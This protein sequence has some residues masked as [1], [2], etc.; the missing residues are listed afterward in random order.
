MRL[1]TFAVVILLVQGCRSLQPAISTDSKAA[2]ELI[3]RQFAFTEGPA[4]DKNGN[5]YFTD[6]PNNSIWKYTTKGELSL[7]MSNSGRSNG[8]FFDGAGNLIACADENNELWSIDENGN[9]TVLLAGYKGERFNG[10]NDVWVST[11]GGIYFTDPHYKRAYWTLTGPQVKGQHVYFLPKGASEAVPV[12]TDLKQPNGIIGS[13]DGKYLYVA[14][15]GAWKTYRYEIMENGLLGKAELF[16]EQGS[17]GMTTDK[18]GN[19]YLTGK[20]VT[21]YNSSGRLIKNIEVPEEWT[22]NVTL[23]GRKRDV[24]FITASKGIYKIKL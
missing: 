15:I 10:P 20:G 9:H 16:A 17:D 11:K 19:I 13:V 24:L 2:P 22:A 18:K 1:W 3:S 23:M 5:V 6:Q 12:I 14:D 4:T 21:V 7:F 8:L